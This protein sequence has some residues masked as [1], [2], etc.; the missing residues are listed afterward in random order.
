MRKNPRWY[1]PRARWNALAP[2]MIVLSTSKNA[3][4]PGPS[5]AVTAGPAAGTGGAGV[6]GRLTHPVTVTTARDRT[7]AA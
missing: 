3:P 2:R 6:P 5:G 7:L 4:T 1:R